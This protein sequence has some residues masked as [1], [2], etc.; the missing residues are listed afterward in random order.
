MVP[1]M[2]DVLAA[3]ELTLRVL[4]PGDHADVHAIFSDPQTHTI[5]D[6]PVR[7]PEETRLWLERRAVRRDSHG[8]T[9]YGVCR[10][11]GTM[12]GTAG[13]LIGRTA[14]YPELGLEIRW[15][16]QGRGFGTTAAAAVVAEGHRAGFGQVWASVRSWN[17]ASLRVLY[18]IGFRRD[19][20]EGNLIYL[21][22]STRVA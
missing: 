11:D 13:L 15:P 5:G 7:D 19:R 2:S 17:A 6:G 18:R 12:I 20:S 14:P 16:D 3:G 1:Q 4:T 8:V 10:S 22:H 21:M 9:W